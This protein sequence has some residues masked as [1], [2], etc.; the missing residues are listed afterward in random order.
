MRIEVLSTLVAVVW[1]TAVLCPRQ[2]VAVANNLTLS[3]FPRKGKGIHSFREH[4][5]QITLEGLLNKRMTVREMDY[6]LHQETSSRTVE[7]CPEIMHM[8]EPIGGQNHRNMFV[9]LFRDGEIAQ[10]FFEYSCRA[11]VLDRPCKFIDWRLSN[12]SKCVQKFAYVYAIVN[13]TSEQG[14]EGYNAANAKTKWTLDYIRVRSGCSCE[15]M[16]KSKKKKATSSKSRRTKSKLHQPK[17]QELDFE[18]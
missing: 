1:L 11:D 6:F 14:Y 18:T 12:R 7:C 5:A 13:A 15:I 9:E 10:R 4:L 3:F 8:V 2:I 17:D 16:P